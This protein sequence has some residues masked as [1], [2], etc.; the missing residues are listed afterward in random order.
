MPP[1]HRGVY[2]RSANMTIA[3]KPRAKRVAGFLNAAS[4]NEIIFNAAARTD[5]IIWCRKLGNK[6][7]RKG[8]PDQMA[9]AAG[10]SF[11]YRA[12]AIARRGG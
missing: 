4:E 7:N 8:G 5:S 2:A 9:V 1:L 6:F 3:Y 12:R 10:A 11:E